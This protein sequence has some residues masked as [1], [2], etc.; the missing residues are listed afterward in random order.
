[1]RTQKKPA[2]ILHLAGFFMTAAKKSMP[3]SKMITSTAQSSCGFPAYLPCKPH[4][5]CVLG[6][7]LFEGY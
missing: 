7:P 5:D 6:M 1:L 3:K 2:L 4:G